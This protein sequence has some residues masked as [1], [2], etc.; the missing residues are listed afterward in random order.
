MCV[1]VSVSVSFSFSVSVSVSFSVC[2]SVC[3]C[4]SVCAHT[5]PYS[6]TKAR[7]H[8]QR[9]AEAVKSTA[10]AHPRRASVGGPLQNST[11][12]AALVR[13]AL[14]ILS[15]SP[16]LLAVLGKPPYREGRLQVC[17][18]ACVYYSLSH[19]HSPSLPPSLPLSCA[20]ITCTIQ[21]SLI[22]CVCVCTCV[23]RKAPR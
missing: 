21:H 1:S 16:A 19:T 15:A 23:R 9:A 13:E 5:I 10:P 3:L 8:V 22:V 4:V 7:M 20:N 18:C 12:H 11:E 2:L 17:A 14:E 6:L